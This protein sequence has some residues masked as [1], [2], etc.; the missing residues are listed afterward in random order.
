MIKILVADDHPI[1]REGIRRVVADTTDI[2]IAD[3]VSTG[4]EVLDLVQRKHYDLIV[5]DI[6][7]PGRSGL[8]ILKDLKG[9]KPNLPVLILTVH[10][11][12]D[13]A[14]RVLNEGA[15]GYLT[16]E[17]SPDQLIKA[18]HEVVKG[19]KYIS[20]TLAEELLLHTVKGP[21]APIHRRLSNREYQI[22]C[23]IAQGKNIRNIAEELTV[24]IKTVES[25]RTRIK[26]KMGLK[27]NAEIIRYAMKN[28]LTD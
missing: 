21:L 8:D 16:K 4:Y 25:H 3:E 18:I 6:S 5:L 15:S 10:P 2:V 17:K 20:S 26:V 7:M 19:H 14:I 11:E 27:S 22:M 9:L 28:R 1:V 24:S 12:K 13:L 23:L